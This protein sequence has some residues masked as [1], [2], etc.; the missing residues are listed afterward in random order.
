VSASSSSITTAVTSATMLDYVP[1]SLVYKHPGKYF[2]DYGVEQ[3]TNARYIWQYLGSRG[4]S[5]NAV[6]GILGNIQTESKMNPALLEKTSSVPW[7][8]DTSRSSV[9]RYANG[10]RAVKG[11]FP[12]YGL[13]QWTGKS[14]SCSSFDDWDNHKLIK[15]CDNNGKDPT[16]IDSQLDRII[17]EMEHNIQFGKTNAYPMTFREFSVSTLPASYLGKA[18]LRNYERPANPNYE[19]RGQQA[20]YWY[21]YLISYTPEQVIT[22]VLSLEN[23]KVAA[24]G[25]TKMNLSFVVRSGTKGLYRLFSSTDIQLDTKVFDIG[26]NNNDAAQ[27]M[28][29]SLTNLTPNT[30]YKVEVEVAGT[31]GGDTLSKKISFLT[32]QDLPAP[33]AN[34]T[35]TSNDITFPFDNF[36]LTTG[37]VSN[38]G[39][40]KRNN[41]G[42]V[43]QLIVNGKC[44]SEKTIQNL[45]STLNFK[46]S[47]YFTNYRSK[48]G[49]T[50]QIGVRTWVT[51]NNGNKQYDSFYAKTSN[52]ICLLKQPILTYLNTD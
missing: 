22:P 24:V 52:P 13:T 3:Q 30:F 20:E 5:L 4:W 6:A 44:V 21:N 19:K 11:R 25:S 10:Y 23:V 36:K 48:L 33:V 9:K 34:L 7:P 32:P 46:I 49:D 2:A 39:Y 31:S 26:V 37:A 29:F 35:L 47:N 50:I 8:A 51:D 45:P 43:I 17:Y 1:K 28:S 42:Y 15:W 40:W 12:G 41:Y 16:D 38:W 18:F 14:E 27:A